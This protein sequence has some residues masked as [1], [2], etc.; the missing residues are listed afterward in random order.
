MQLNNLDLELDVIE[1]E[2]LNEVVVYGVTSTGCCG[3]K[4]TK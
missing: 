1:V 2:T 4:K 3:T